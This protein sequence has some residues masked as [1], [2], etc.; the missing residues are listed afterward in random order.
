M[1]T[2]KKS[3][4]LSIAACFGF[5]AI[6]TAAVGI[7][8]FGQVGTIETNLVFDVGFLLSAAFVYAALYGLIRLL[9][10]IKKSRVFIRENVTYLRRISWC[11]FGV[12]AV[13]LIGGLLYKG[14]PYSFFLFIAFLAAAIG[15]VLRVVKNVM[16]C[17]VE[18]KAENELTI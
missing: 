7:F 8:L 11:C 9:F 4:A 12:T 5:A 15:L 18:L 17:A 3:V 10:N 2:S 13:A 16:E 6:L 14:L 1:W